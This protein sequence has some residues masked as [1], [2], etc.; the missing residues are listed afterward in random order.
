MAE[1]LDRR[2]YTPVDLDRILCANWLR[3]LGR[4]L[5]GV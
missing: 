4:V 3:L 5:R 2:G 1:I